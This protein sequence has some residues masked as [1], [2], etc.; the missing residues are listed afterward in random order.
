MPEAT[1]LSAGSRTG[2]SPTEEPNTIYNRYPV[3][4]SANQ[5]HHLHSLCLPSP[6]CSLTHPAWCS[7]PALQ[8]EAAKVRRKFPGSLYAEIFQAEASKF[9]STGEGDGYQSLSFGSQV[10]QRLPGCVM[11]MGVEYDTLPSA[12]GN[13]QRNL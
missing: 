11:S 8:A 4:V 2:G 5:Q 9:P 3:R 10:W 13:S 1:I 7:E 12:L 6:E